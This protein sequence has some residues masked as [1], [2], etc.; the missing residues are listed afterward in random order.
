MLVPLRILLTAV[1][2]SFLAKH[3]KRERPTSWPGD[4]DPKT[5]VS[6][7]GAYCSKSGH[8]GIFDSL[9]CII[10]FSNTDF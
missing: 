7:D 4:W 3:A 2:D 5:P 1:A 9:M 10:V 6:R 8:L